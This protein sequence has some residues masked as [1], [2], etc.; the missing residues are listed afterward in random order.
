[1]SALLRAAQGLLRASNDQV[2]V[3]CAGFALDGD[4]IVLLDLVGYKT[5]LKSMWATV[6]G[7]TR[8]PFS[9]YG[10]TVGT[11]RVHGGDPS[12]AT[13]RAF[14]QPLHEQN[15]HNLVI[16]HAQMIAS[17]TPTSATVSVQ[18]FYVLDDG[19]PQRPVAARFLT[20]LNEAL[21]LPLLST[22]ADWLW[23][24]GIDGNLVSALHIGGDVIGAWRV[25]TGGDAWVG[26]VQGGLVKGALTL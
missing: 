13:Y 7:G 24:A 14:W 18:P 12:T 4:M 16:A 26:L 5:A 11:L 22:W 15:A 9:L 3:E 20:L 19:H 25:E 8:K 21:D 2:A 6:V 1:M 17:A 10:E 23:Q